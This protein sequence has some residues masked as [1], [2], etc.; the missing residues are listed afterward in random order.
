MFFQWVLCA[1]IWT[2]SLIVN[3]ILNCP[4][5]WPL[6]MLGGAIWATGKAV[7]VPASGVLRMWSGVT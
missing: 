4:K 1:A 3:L 6:A 2:V 7:S 5:F